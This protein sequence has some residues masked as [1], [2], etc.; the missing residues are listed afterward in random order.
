MFLHNYTD[1]RNRENLSAG[2]D[3]PAAARAQAAETTAPRSRANPVG[4]HAMVRTI[5]RWECRDCGAHA[6][7]RAYRLK[8]AGQ[9]CRGSVRAQAAA[10]GR[11]RT[12]AGEARREHVLRERA[13]ITY[14]EKCGGW[15]NGRKVQ[16][17]KKGC[18][19]PTAWGGKVLER[20]RKACHPATGKSLP[21]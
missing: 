1:C 21:V 18:A 13:G 3:T 5:G 4:R 20:F 16:K 10:A 6:T 15:S 2:T 14:C 9:T 17:L 19:P 8:L 11:D 7:T 12:L